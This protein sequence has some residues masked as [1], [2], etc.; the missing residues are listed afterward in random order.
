MRRSGSGL[1]DQAEARSD[2]RKR[3]RVVITRNA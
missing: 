3:E 1:G 2:E